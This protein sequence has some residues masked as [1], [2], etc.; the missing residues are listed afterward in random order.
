VRVIGVDG[1]KGCLYSGSEKVKGYRIPTLL[2][3]KA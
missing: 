1:D 3:G 2:R